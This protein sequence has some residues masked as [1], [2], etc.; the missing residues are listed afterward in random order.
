MYHEVMNYYEEYYSEIS[1]YVNLGRDA[2]F[3]R[4]SMNNGARSNSA[5][6]EFIQVQI[7]LINA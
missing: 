1:D 4:Q 2:N 5:A 7:C 3:R 6:S